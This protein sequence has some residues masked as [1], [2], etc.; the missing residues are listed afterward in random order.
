[1]LV[2]PSSS[3]QKHEVT[4]STTATETGPVQLCASCQNFKWPQPPIA[5]NQIYDV[6]PPHKTFLALEE[7]AVA[8]CNLCQLFWGCIINTENCANKLATRFLSEA[9]LSLE[10]GNFEGRIDLNLYARGTS[11]YVYGFIELARLKANGRKQSAQVL[12]KRQ[13]ERKLK[14]KYRGKILH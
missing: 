14:K 2:Q 6:D 5:D 12:E 13:V 7:S 10:I 9:S 4:M 1:M 3:R 8:G 11:D